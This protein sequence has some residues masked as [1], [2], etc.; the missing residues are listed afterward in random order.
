MLCERC[1]QRPATVRLQQ[2]VNG[3]K[4]EHHLCQE[5]AAALESPLS[6][7]QFFQNM[8]NVFAASHDQE[9]GGLNIG[10]EYREILRCPRCHMTIMDFKNTGKLGCCECYKTFG[11]EMDAVLKNVHGSSLH[12]GKI[13]R[14]SGAKFIT[15]RMIDNLRVSLSKAV[16]AEEYEE[17]ARIRDK[18]K[19]LEAESHG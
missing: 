8:I 4:T 16:A 17:A 15:S 6:F 11:R 7:Q 3:G 10:T 1:K 9:K 19:K 12:Q 14:K 13:P 5:C 18:I 2:I